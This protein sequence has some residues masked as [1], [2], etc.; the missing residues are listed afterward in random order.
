MTGRSSYMTYVSWEW[1][2]K[3]DSVLGAVPFRLMDGTAMIEPT[4]T[5]IG[6]RV[7]RYD[8]E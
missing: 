5:A 1:R 4:V 3:Q 8:Q 2:R 6:E 7:I